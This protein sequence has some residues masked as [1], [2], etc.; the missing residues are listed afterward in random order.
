MAFFSFTRNILEGKPIQIF[1]NGH[2][3]RDFTYVDDIVNGVIRISDQP[4]EP[5]AV[6]SGLHPDPAT[7]TA[8]YRIFNIGNGTRVPLMDYVN[9]IED[10]AGKKALIEYLPMQPGDVP[11]THADVSAL[12]AQVAFRPSISVREGMSKFV[13]WYRDYYV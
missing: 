8:P 7:S 2:H 5:S 6:W 9:A 10:A 4:A 11:D 3:S 1:N 13:A 12:E